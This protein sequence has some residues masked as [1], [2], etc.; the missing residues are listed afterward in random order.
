MKAQRLLIGLESILFKLCNEASSNITVVVFGAPAHCRIRTHELFGLRV[1]T[2]SG[3]ASKRLEFEL[4][5]ARLESPE[6]TGTLA[7]VAF[8]D[9]GRIRNDTRYSLPRCS[10]PP[11]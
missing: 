4:N 5:A 3:R 10:P 2:L 9:P 11:S 7:C 6:D 8:G 1:V